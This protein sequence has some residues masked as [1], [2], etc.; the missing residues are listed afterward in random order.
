MKILIKNAHIINADNSITADIFISDGKI[1]KI[2]KDIS[3]NCK[4]DRIINASGY[5]VFPGGIDPHVHFDLPTNAG[6]SAD[7][8]YTGT[9]A[10]LHGGTT[11]V[12]DFVTPMRGQSITKAFEQR[13]QEAKM[14][15][16]N[17]LFHVSPVEWRASTK[18][19]IEEIIKNYNVKSFK[20]YMAY[21]QTVGLN[22][23]DLKRVMALIGKRGGLVTVHAEMGNNIEHLRNE[24]SSS[25]FSETE[26]HYLSRPPETESEAVK[27]AIDFAYETNCPLYI[28]HVSTKK[29]LDH[30]AQAQKNGQLVYAETC[31]H[32]LL[33][34]KSK[35]SDEF[36][37][38]A[39]FVMSPPLRNKADNLA[40]WQ[41][42]ENGTFQT[43]GTD[44][45]PFSLE[46][47]RFGENDFRKIPNGVG[48]VEHRLELLFTFGVMQK[49]ISINKFVE[50]TSTNAAKIFGLYPKKGI[51]ATGSDA[52]IVIW[53]PSK[54]QKISVENHHQNCDLNIYEGLSTI[55]SPEYVILN[56]E[57]VIEKGKFL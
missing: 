19:E 14:A 9:K 49:K 43:L 51:I 44:H 34:D 32:Y 35:Y 21:K 13:T 18:T 17:Y 55:G 16:S 8:F 46:Q 39:A 40:L 11:T 4:A 7:N 26:K 50:I 28:V 38:S 33:F 29:S 20:T 57:I 41:A 36:N 10:A 31:P 12:I 42:I 25:N 30:I 22:F 5:Y 2:E 6:K 24:L 52:D 3:N 15:V 45:C 47:K 23:A 48:G 37:K 27:M 54:T 56:G 53:N 1:S